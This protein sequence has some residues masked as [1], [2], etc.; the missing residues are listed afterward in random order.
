MEI[1]FV[2]GAY[3]SRSSN[4][5]AQ[6]C[7]NLI[8]ATDQQSPKSTTILIGTPGITEFVD[9]SDIAPPPPPF[10]WVVRLDDTY[11]TGLNGVWSGTSWDV[12]PEADEKIY[13]GIME[14]DTW[15][16]GFRPTKIRITGV[17]F[18]AD[19]MTIEDED[20]NTIG[21]GIAADSVEIDLDCVTYDLDIAVLF[22]N[23]M[24]SVTNIEFYVEV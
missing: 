3:A 11:W 22:L 5:N 2:G 8:P 12:P 1:P 19:V 16:V 17:V 4:V 21:T 20:S 9:L 10:E 13:L 24:H 14:P 6:R 18:S 23:G 15:I 7:V